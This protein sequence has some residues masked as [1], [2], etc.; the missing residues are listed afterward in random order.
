MSHESTPTL[1]RPELAAVVCDVLS[2]LAF[3]ISDD[4]QTPL[5]GRRDWLHCRIEYRGAAQGAL[6]CWST[7]EFARQL[8]ATLLGLDPDDDASRNGAT[9]ALREFLNVVCGQLVTAW[10]GR[11]TVCD[12]SVPQIDAQPPPKPAGE[13]VGNACRITVAGEPLICTHEGISA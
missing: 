8:A 10:Y 2:D 1:V 6:H 13:T 5:D 12:L 9:D 4:R 7:G 3:M 11:R